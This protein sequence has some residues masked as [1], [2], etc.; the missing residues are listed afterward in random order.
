MW[1]GE[2]INIGDAVCCEDDPRHIAVVTSIS[3][4][5]TN[6]ED[7]RGSPQYHVKWKETGWH[8]ILNEDDK[9]IRA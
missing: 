9:V 2:Q 5:K 6:V 1:Y 3:F 4:V 7:G 8:S